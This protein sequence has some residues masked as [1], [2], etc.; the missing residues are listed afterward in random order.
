MSTISRE[1]IKKFMIKYCDGNYTAVKSNALDLCK[2]TLKHNE[3]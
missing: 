2:L 3:E 1:K